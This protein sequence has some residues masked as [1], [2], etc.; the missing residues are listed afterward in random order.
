MKCAMYAMRLQSHSPPKQN[1]LLF[2]SLSHTGYIHA[3]LACVKW[4]LIASV[5]LQQLLLYLLIRANIT[6]AGW[7]SHAAVQNFDMTLTIN[8]STPLPP[9]YQFSNIATPT[10]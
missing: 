5:D 2:H 4:M 10:T 9:L 7:W 8:D 3:Q 6:F 1:A